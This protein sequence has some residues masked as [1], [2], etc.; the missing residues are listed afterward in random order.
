MKTRREQRA[1]LKFNTYSKRV[2]MNVLI[3]CDVIVLEPAVD[4][5]RARSNSFILWSTWSDGRT[6]H[7]YKRSRGP[8]LNVALEKIILRSEVL[9]T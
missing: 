6:Y 1:N 8:E 5:T 3:D 9:R 7:T 4:L 2:R